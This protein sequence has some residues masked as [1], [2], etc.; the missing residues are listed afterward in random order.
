[1][2]RKL[3][4]TR[5]RRCQK[6]QLRGADRLLLPPPAP[7]S[8]KAAVL[9]L[10][11]AFAARSP[12]AAP[13]TAREVIERPDPGLARGPWEAPAWIFYA[14]AAAAV[15]GGIGWAATARRG[16]KSAR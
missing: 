13:V 12:D 7:A 14:V 16:S 11:S 9:V 5:P 6:G 4:R 2:G 1:M 3:S 8:T 15:F 10:A